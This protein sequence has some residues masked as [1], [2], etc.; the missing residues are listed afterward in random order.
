[1][2][3]IKPATDPTDRDAA[4][5]ATAVRP[6]PRELLLGHTLLIA[7]A[8]DEDQVIARTLAAI[9]SV[10][11]ADA[12]A[13]IGPDGRRR[14]FGR[15]DIAAVLVATSLSARA[16]SANSGYATPDAPA[17]ISQLGEAI[18]AHLGET[19][20]AR[21]DDTVVVGAN[22][23]AGQFAAGAAGLLALL[24]AHAQASRDRLRQ[25]AS[26]HRLADR[27]PLT[28]L[29]HNGPFARR[30]DTIPAPRCAIIVLDLD[31][32]KRINDEYGHQAGDAALLCVVGALKAD[33]RD[34]D[35]LYRIG[36][37]EFAVVLDVTDPAEVAAIVRRLLDAAR[38][39]GR[40]ISV[41]AAIHQPG[42]AGRDTL[43][44]ADRALYDAK[45]A[46]RNTARLAA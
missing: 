29:C 27:D 16:G 12:A 6:D 28:G 39:V 2:Y 41:G 25:L 35:V 1:M 7:T 8:A 5:L 36:G 32:F 17:A 26:L 38:R 20:T 23:T 30:L 3:L 34:E 44:R 18:T 31:D 37:D 4:L 42:E 45:R 40:P 13:A 24:V 21:L 11:G 22:T 19:I 33:L 14:T 10:T 15:P 9:C 46:G 43:A